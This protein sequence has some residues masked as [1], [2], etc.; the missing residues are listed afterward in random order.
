M[1]NADTAIAT[2]G[3]AIDNPANALYA[4]SFVSA[5]FKT[6]QNTNAKTPTT[7]ELISRPSCN[8][9][10]DDFFF[11]IFYINVLIWHS[12]SLLHV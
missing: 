8:Q 11:V 2:N 3:K 6:K 7:A 10:I 12:H 5:R 4:A 1:H 9:S